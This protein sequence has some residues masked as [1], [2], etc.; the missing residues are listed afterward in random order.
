MA[1]PPPFPHIEQLIY[2]NHAAV[3]PWPRVT[4]E[5]VSRF[6][7]ENAYCGARNY[8][9]WM[10]TEQRLKRN[11]ATLINAPDASDIALVKNTSEA[12][13][14]VAYGLD[15][16]VGDNIVISD[17]EFPS[18]RIV[19]ESLAQFGVAVRQVDLSAAATPE[20]ALLNQIDQRTRLLSISSIE[21]ASG[22][23]IRLAS[24]GE[25]CRVRQIYFC[26]DAIQSI[27]AATLDVEAI[28]ADFVM[29]DGHKWMLGPE[30][31]ALFYCRREVRDKLRLHQYG[32][33]MVDPMGDYDNPEWR[34]ASSARRFECGSPNMLAIHALDASITLLLN[35]GIARIEAA[36]VDNA[37][38]LIEAIKQRPA[39]QLLT[40]DTPSRLGGI[41]TFKATEYDNRH[42]YQQL[43]N[44][45]IICALRGGGI[46][47]SPH[48]YTPKSQLIEAM[49]QVDALIGECSASRRG[50]G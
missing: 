43:M 19:W 34:I 4:A 24:L 20:E 48:F 3:A 9:V 21:Y 7:Q 10:K 23:K 30:G 2:L 46:R 42:L 45:N 25:F 33:H 35:E 11:L 22:L 41:V 18:N 27:G 14:L 13:S 6:A 31:L 44:R 32:W 12:L 1:T 39:L 36:V 8:P 38:F 40:D 37:T 17:Q 5:A 16:Q 28:N 49:Q 47:F 15:W 26:V 50:R 29:A